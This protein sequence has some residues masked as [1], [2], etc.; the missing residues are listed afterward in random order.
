MTGG[1]GHVTGG[2]VIDGHVTG[3]PDQGTDGQGRA[4]GGHGHVIGGQDRVIGGHDHVGGGHGH[5]PNQR[6]TGIIPK[7]NF[8]SIR[9]MFGITGRKEVLISYIFV[10]N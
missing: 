8:S 6:L 7:C 1:R 3:V 4:I 2:H 5:F 9:E 10:V